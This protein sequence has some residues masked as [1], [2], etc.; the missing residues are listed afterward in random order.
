MVNPCTL[1]CYFPFDT[2]FAFIAYLY[3]YPNVFKSIPL[4]IGS[5][6]RK[7]ILMPYDWPS[8]SVLR[9]LSI[10]RNIEIRNMMLL[11][12]PSV[13]SIFCWYDFCCEFLKFAL[14][15]FGKK[16]LFL[17]YLFFSLPDDSLLLSRAYLKF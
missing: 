3:T 17:A 8:R 2:N 11:H 13:L 7:T 12:K 4:N 1:V 14:C 10:V 5:W 16:L 9:W 15:I 6:I